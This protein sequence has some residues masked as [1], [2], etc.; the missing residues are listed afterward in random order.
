MGILAEHLGAVLY[1]ADKKLFTR[2]REV[3]ADFVN[4]P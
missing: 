1:T 2:C 4:L 3:G